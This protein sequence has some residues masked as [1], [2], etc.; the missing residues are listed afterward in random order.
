MQLFMAKIIFKQMI[1]R[2]NSLDS[3]WDIHNKKYEI[4]Q[5]NFSGDDW[6]IIYKMPNTSL[7]SLT[8]SRNDLPVGKEILK[9][10]GEN[11]NT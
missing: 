5:I 3:L 6:V 4:K 7:N 2:R 11:K 9:L 10:Y 8:W 1:Y